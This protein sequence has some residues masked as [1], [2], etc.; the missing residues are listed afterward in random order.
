MVQGPP[1]IDN[2][3]TVGEDDITFHDS[4]SSMIL[5][6]PEDIGDIKNFGGDGE[7]GDGEG[8]AEAREAQ[9]VAPRKPSRTP[10]SKPPQ[11]QQDSLTLLRHG[12]R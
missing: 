9:E 3:G 8:A 2:I 10:K 4:S 7:D 5:P 12:I 1:P 11:K 6:I